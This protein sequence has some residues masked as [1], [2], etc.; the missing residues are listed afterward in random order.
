M[1]QRIILIGLSG[2]GKS[3]LAPQV[4]RELGYSWV[5]TDSE[6]SQRFGAPIPDIFKN[7]GELTFRSVE[8]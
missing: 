6:I 7:F 4:A 8:R 2:T 5:D 3:S 1:L